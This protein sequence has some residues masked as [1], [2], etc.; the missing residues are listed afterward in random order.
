MKSFDEERTKLIE[1]YEAELKPIKDEMED[2]KA[3]EITKESIFIDF[4]FLGHYGLLSV[5]LGHSTSAKLDQCRYLC[6]NRNKLG[7]LTQVNKQYS[8]LQMDFHVKKSRMNEQ[9]LTL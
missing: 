5:I 6:K 7:E 4:N 3:Q 8:E 2:L 1:D 9:N